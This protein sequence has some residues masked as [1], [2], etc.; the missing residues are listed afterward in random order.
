MTPQQEAAVVLVV[1]D[2]ETG[3]YAKARILKRAGYEVVEAA[4]GADALRLA[5]ER[6]PRVVVLD[7]NLPDITGWENNPEDIHRT[8]Y[9]CRKKAAG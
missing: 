8:R 1:D 9:M 5:A 6:H 7:I 3:R 4:T 2:N